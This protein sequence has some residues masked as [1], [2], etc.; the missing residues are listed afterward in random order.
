MSIYASLRG[1][2]A[3]LWGRGDNRGQAPAA[4]AASPE[5]RPAVN[6]AQAYGV[7]IEPADVAPGGWYWQAVRVHHLTPEENNGNHHIFVD[8][9]DLELD[10]SNPLGGRVQG[11]RVRVTWDGGEQ[12]ATVDKPLSEPGTNVPM[13]RWQVCTLQALGLPG[14]ELPSDR[15]TGLQTGH[16]E[17]APGNTLF[18]HS[19]EI[20][21]LKVQAP[22]VIYRDSIIYGT[23]RRGAGRTAQLLRE[24]MIVAEQF[25]STDEAFRFADLGAGE[26]V[27]AVAGTTFRSAPVRVTGRDQAQRDLQLMLAESQ[28]SG[29]V[30]QGAGRT[31]RL[32]RDG[33]EVA[34]QIVAEDE[35]YQFCGL[36]EGSYQVTVADADVMSS[37]LTLDGVNA[38]V[39]DLFAPAQG[40][41]IGHYVLF[42]PAG[43]PETLANLVLAEDFLLAFKPSFGFSPAEAA[44]ASM[45][46]LIAGPDA[47]SPEIEAEL[48]AGGALVQRIAGTVEEV[49]T[50]LAER[51]TRGQA[52]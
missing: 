37:V 46:T 8:L 33:V 52:F 40:K 31:V 39:A 44:G 19:F 28:V 51:I 26:Y 15:V 16:P 3:R 35:R 24:D 21:Y 32:L 4:T 9:R 38:A 5:P 6:D 42:G 13:W 10:S 30:R 12:I 20:V 43:Q 49:A 2:F 25:V 18:H 47:V 7:A 11:A 17:E 50:G 29:S 48:T 34:S 41:L 14:A 45:V 27:L 36:T 1:F 22:T 23:L